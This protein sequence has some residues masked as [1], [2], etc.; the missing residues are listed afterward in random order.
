MQ[1]PRGERPKEETPGA[2]VPAPAGAQ[3]SLGVLPEDAVEICRFLGLS[4]CRELQPASSQFGPSTRLAMLEHQEQVAALLAALKDGNES[5]RIDAVKALGAQAE[6]GNKKVIA[7]V[8]GLLKVHGNSRNYFPGGSNFLFESV[9]VRIEAV[10]A[11][12]QLTEKGNEEVRTQLRARLTDNSE[13]VDVRAHALETLTRIAPEKGGNPVV[14]AEEVSALLENVSWREGA[15]GL[16]IIAQIVQSGN[17]EV[18]EAV[19]VCL[20]TAKSR[21]VRFDVFQVL[22]RFAERDNEKVINAVLRALKE[23]GDDM[24]RESCLEILERLAVSEEHKEKVM[25]AKKAYG[26]PPVFPPLLM[27]AS[28]Y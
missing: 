16:Q 19:L 28:S 9:A 17:E 1:A 4:S 7:A 3:S 12:I 22:G 18:I 14:S 21:V 13:P 5:V 26:G 15:R 27:R 24:F 25:E 10:K 8:L 11:L 23:G 6:R 20:K 2:L